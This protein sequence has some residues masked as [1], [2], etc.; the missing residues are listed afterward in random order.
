MNNVCREPSTAP[1]LKCLNL[2]MVCVSALSSLMTAPGPQHGLNVAM[3]EPVPDESSK[4]RAL[5]TAAVR[6]QAR[7]RSN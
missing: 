7:Q 1:K 5:T 6:Q 2:V 4:P 3:S